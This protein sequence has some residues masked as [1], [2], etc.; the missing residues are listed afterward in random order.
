MGLT[1]CYLSLCLVNNDKGTITCGKKCFL[2]TELPLAEA[3]C[4]PAQTIGWEATGVGFPIYR[5]PR[6]GAC[7]LG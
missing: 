4:D 6:H 3:Y 1:V 5:E 2:V 7:L